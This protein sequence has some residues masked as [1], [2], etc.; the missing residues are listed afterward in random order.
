MDLIYF[1]ICFAQP[2][3]LFTP[4]MVTITAGS[5]TLG[6]F[7]GF[8][9]GYFGIL[10][11]IVTMYFMGRFAQ[12]RIVRH[13]GKEELFN[14]YTRLVEKNGDVIIGVL[15]ILPIL[16][17]NIICA[18]AGI[19]KVSLKRFIFIAAISKLITTFLYAYSVELANVFSIS[20]LQLILS[21]LLIMTLIVL[22]N[23]FIKK[24]EPRKMKQLHDMS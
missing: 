12:Q 6:A 18:G 16:P 22:V 20:K 21:K 2:I 9:I 3:I 24:K 14:K 7:K 4:E 23:Q 11:G 5:L 17:D 1:F 13:I 15:F 8:M 19:S 10:M